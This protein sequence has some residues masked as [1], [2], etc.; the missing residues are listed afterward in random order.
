ML[1]DV[2]IAVHPTTRATRTS[3]GARVL[4]PPLLERAIPIVADAAVDREF[5]TGAVKVTPAHDATDYEIGLRHELPMPSVIGLDAR[6][7]GAEI[8]VGPYAASIASKRASA[9]SRTCARWAARR[10][11][12]RIGTP[13]RRASARGDVIEPLLSLQWFVKM[14]P[15]AKPALDAYHDGRAA[16]RSRALRPHVRAVAREHSRLERLAADVVGAS[17]AR[18]V[19]AGRHAKS[20]PKPKKKRARSRCAIY[21][22]DDLTRDPDTLDTWFSSGIW[23][24]SI[25]GWPERRRSCA[26][27]T[28]R[29]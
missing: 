8:G 7:T 2:A 1:A 5:G 14:A 16:F 3:S 27:G 17:A 21:G 28:R 24:F 10:R 15:L 23:P 11:R 9:S 26:A 4:V 22:T 13:S 18:L 6:I 12:S 20:S 19:R 25:L 29:R